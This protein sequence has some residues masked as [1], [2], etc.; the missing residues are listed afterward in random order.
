MIENFLIGMILIALAA[1]QK[2]S[3]IYISKSILY[4]FRH[5]HNL[6]AVMTSKSV[7]DEKAEK[8]L[9]KLM[10]I[11]GFDTVFGSVR[12]MMLISLLAGISVGFLGFIA[13]GMAIG[14]ISLVFITFLP[15]LTMKVLLNKK[16]IKSSMEGDIMIQEF[17]ANYKIHDCNIK[18]AVDATAKSLKNTPFSRGIMQNLAIDLGTASTKNEI[19][20]AVNTLKYSL[21]T[22]WG[23]A[24]GNSIYL[25]QLHGLKINE[26]LEDL[27][28]TICLCKRAT[29][30]ERREHNEARLMIKYLAP[31][32]YILS[33]WCGCRY[34]GFTLEKFLKYQFMTNLGIKWFIIVLLF[35]LA[36]T[37]IYSYLSKEKMDI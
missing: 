5:R 19:E 34:F 13:G 23:N 11:T 30:H 22:S 17:L 26:A 9:F 36:G 16:R 15:V 33:I 14:S 25:G 7:I 29:E 1:W 12:Q 20:K 4:R 10:K 32:T 8:E 18:D 24:L 2:T 3:I 27:S 35:Y 31:M 28:K 21:D 37:L 6:K